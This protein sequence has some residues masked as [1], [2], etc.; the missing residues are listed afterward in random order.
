MSPKKTKSFPLPRVRREPPTIEEAVLAAEGLAT[1][2]GQ[3]A[4]IA[5]GLMGVTVDEVKP[6]LTRL[7]PRQDFVAM[8]GRTVTVERVKRFATARR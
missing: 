1:E 8:G 3:Q 5:A 2:P 6:F 4:E 7:R